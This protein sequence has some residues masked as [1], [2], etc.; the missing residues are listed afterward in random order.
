MDESELLVLFARLCAGA[1]VTVLVVDTLRRWW[2]RRR[3]EW[4]PP[5]RPIRW[6]RSFLREASWVGRRRR[7]R[8]LLLVTRFLLWVVALLLVSGWLGWPLTSSR[9]PV[10]ALVVTAFTLW[11]SVLVA[12][13]L[14]RRRP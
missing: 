8:R 12:T 10:F 4:R 13:S 7:M 11:L 5:S 14:S 2:L 3:A 9:S 6:S 1:A